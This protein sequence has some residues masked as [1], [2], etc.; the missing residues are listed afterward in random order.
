MLHDD[1]LQNQVVITTHLCTL[2]SALFLPDFVLFSLRLRLTMVLF[3]GLANNHT[4]YQTAVLLFIMVS[5]RGD[6]KHLLL[7]RDFI[8]LSTSTKRME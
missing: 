5:V 1:M 4:S 8:F 2:S 6:E 3:T 7:K